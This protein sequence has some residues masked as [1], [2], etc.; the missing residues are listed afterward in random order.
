MTLPLT[1]QFRP[2]ALGDYLLVEDQ[3]RVNKYLNH[4]DQ[5][6]HL[7]LVGPPGTGKT[8]FARVLAKELLG[9]L[10]QLNFLELNASSERGVD[11]I[12]D[13]VRDFVSHSMQS[14]FR[15]QNCK[16]DYKIVLFDEADALTSDAQTALRNV[17]ETYAYNS[18]IFFSCNDADKLITP[19]KSRCKVEHFKPFSEAAVETILRH[20]SEKAN[21]QVDDKVIKNIIKKTG[22][23]LRKAINELAILEDQQVQLSKPLFDP[24][25]V[26]AMFNNPTPAILRELYLFFQFGNKSDETKQL[27][28]IITK[29]LLEQPYDTNKKIKLLAELAKSEY[30]MMIGGSGFLSTVRFL[31][32]LRQWTD[33]QN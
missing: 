11:T 16:V 13:T 30:A 8:T 14:Y 9:E 25:I 29:K 4:K 7:I 28:R 3:N 12:R 24:R 10:N 31:D 2:R 20:H 27:Y 19:L 22:G 15:N 18:R 32:C 21:L 6:P 5:L 1:E 33:S 17:M 23:D 26:D